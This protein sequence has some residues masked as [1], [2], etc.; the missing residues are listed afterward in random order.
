MFADHAFPESNWVDERWQAKKKE[1]RGRGICTDVESL[2]LALELSSSSVVEQSRPAYIRFVFESRAGS[3]R[4]QGGDEPWWQAFIQRRGNVWTSGC[5][6]NT[7]AGD[8]IELGYG[9]KDD[10]VRKAADISRQGVFRQ[11]VDERLVEENVDIAFCSSCDKMDE[12]LAFA[13]DTG[14]V[15]WIGQEDGVLFSR[16]HFIGVVMEV[17]FRAKYVRGDMHLG[18]LKSLAVFDKCGYRQEAAADRQRAKRSSEERDEAVG[19]DDVLMGDTNVVRYRLLQLGF[20]DVGIAGNDR[21]IIEAC[22]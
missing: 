22:S 21:E 17:A 6:G 11:I 19:H 16:E 12:R 5:I 13:G 9:A 15:L 14:G 20:L 7:K 1:V 18:A 3:A 8:S 2:N 4:G 10:K